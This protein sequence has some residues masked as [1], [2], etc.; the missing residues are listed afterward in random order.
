MADK[1]ALAVRAKILGV[2]LRDARL[3]AG[4]SLKDCATVLGGT[5]GA[6]GDCE[7][8][9]KPLSLPELEILAFYL[10][11]P[12]SHFWGSEIISDDKPASAELHAGELLAL[13][14]RLIGAK[15]RAARTAAGVKRKELAAEA[16]IS[17]GR[18]SAYEFGEKSIPI[19]EL[20]VLARALGLTVDHFLERQGPIGEWDANRRAYERFEQ[21]PP[22]LREFLVEPVN[23]SYLR[24]A[25]QLAHLSVEKLRG[26]AEGILDITY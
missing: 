17:P 16:G 1:E 19:P 13:R 6:Y 4:K 25:M 11:T 21:L 23:E 7:L 26:I 20:E 8:G 14:H 3:A 2:L 9:R 12:L 22:D 18:L 15:L 24:L 10:D 5:P